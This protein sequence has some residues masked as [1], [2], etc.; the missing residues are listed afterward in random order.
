MRA[1]LHRTDLATEDRF[2]LEFALG[3]A[4]EDAGDYPESFARYASGAASRR[5][6][7]DYEADETTAQMRRSKR[8]F[9]PAF[10]KARAGVGCPASDPIF[11]VD[12]ARSGSPLAD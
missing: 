5:Q 3:K 12:L 9:T 11:V 2:H 10:F 4:L 6:S 1:Q 8:L 7:L